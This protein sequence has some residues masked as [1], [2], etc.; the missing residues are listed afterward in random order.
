M[1]CT[2]DMIRLG[3]GCVNSRHSATFPNEAETTWVARWWAHQITAD[4]VGG[5]AQERVEMIVSELVANAVV[6]GEGTITVDLTR[7]ASCVVISIQDEGD[8]DV[9]I[10]E[11]EHERLGYGLPIVEALAL[12]WGVHR[13]PGEAGKRVWAEVDDQPSYADPS[14]LESLGQVSR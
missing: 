11:G 3:G 7:L 9:E 12:R 1:Q 4:W 14:D 10:R 13:L 8:G 2:K 5:D 6:H